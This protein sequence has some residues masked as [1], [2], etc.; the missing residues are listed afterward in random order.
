[1]K[2]KEQG[3]MKERNR[4]WLL[5][6]LLLAV[7]VGLIAPSMLYLNNYTLFSLKYGAVLPAILL[8]FAAVL[9]VGVGIGLLITFWP[10]LREKLADYMYV[11]YGILIAL[12]FVFLVR[13][14]Y[15]S[16]VVPALGIVFA[17]ML[18][19]WQRKYIYLIYGGM[20]A[21]GF[22]FFRQYQY[23]LITFL[24]WAALLAMLANKK[25][26]PIYI[27]SDIVFGLAIA[28]CCQLWLANGTLQVLSS[29]APNWDV[30]SA[31]AVL[32]LHLWGLCLLLPVVL[33]LI[34]VKTLRFVKKVGSLV[35]APALVVGLVVALLVTELPQINVVTKDDEFVMS[36]ED[37]VVLFLV[38]SL[39]MKWAARHLSRRDARPE[40]FNDFT[41]FTNV[42]GGG[43]PA[44]LGVPTL[45][46]GQIFD[47]AYLETDD[48]LG[49]YKQ[50][51][52]AASPLFSDLKQQGYD[53]DLFTAT[54]YLSEADFESI[55]N[56][57]S[58]IDFRTK[59]YGTL[60]ENLARLTGYYVAP[61]QAKPALWESSSAISNNIE[62]AT[63]GVERYS[64][65]YK[66]FNN[67][68]AIDGMSVEAGR[69]FFKTYT[70]SGLK[71]PDALNAGTA[72]AGEEFPEFDQ[73]L[74]EV[75]GVISTYLET[76]KRNGI[77]DN[78]LIV[79]AGTNGSVE[80]GQ[81]PAVLVKRRDESKA[82]TV[83]ATPLTFANL[84]ATLMDG[85]VPDAQQR[86]GYDM[87]SQPAEAATQLRAHVANKNYWK[88]LY[89]DNG[90]QYRRFN[91]TDKAR[92]EENILKT[93]EAE[94]YPYVLGTWISLCGADA[95][96]D[97]PMTGLRGNEGY[98]NWTLGHDITLGLKLVEEEETAEEKPAETDIESDGM[99][100]MEEDEEMIIEPED[101]EAIEEAGE[102]GA[103][104]QE[105][106]EAE[107]AV[108]PCDTIFEM[109]VVDVL[110][111]QRVKIYVNDHLLYNEI[112]GAPLMITFIIPKEIAPD[113]IY[114][115]VMK[116]PDA[117]SPAELGLNED[118]SVLALQLNGFD[119][120]AM[121]THDM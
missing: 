68:N 7:V 106:A 43:A 35:A 44:G 116:L 102:T 82:L 69:R 62:I 50:D 52:Y 49:N 117:V 15:P 22:V 83:D 53:I 57:R 6:V 67:N 121:E 3:T 56:V 26:K 32:S 2:H 92:G 112:V 105:A 74:S 87:Y 108:E 18:R 109:P 90:S 10:K 88:Q 72:L 78:S 31:G 37:N 120:Y 73:Q 4:H 113:G 46:T 38:D 101:A 63:P 65:G 80:L 60:I 76:M 30:R 119:I 8:C 95:V 12:A 111:P 5:P 94:P 47:T 70:I 100:E 21:L 85:V 98:F 58:D 99:E 28:V 91:I 104:L 34:S 17:I 114:N 27:Y 115:I 54:G 96:Q 110:T 41:F 77:Y 19:N 25:I 33:R 29:S 59:S 48:V 36:N 39:D 11:V 23:P 40:A 97:L 24:I 86:Y 13:D 9:A 75:F 45:L 79:I 42:V 89:S 107:S 61:Y 16:V 1:M 71:I 66:G 103:S 51:A 93:V 64:T 84:R 14:Q 20:L 55:A 118:P 81:N